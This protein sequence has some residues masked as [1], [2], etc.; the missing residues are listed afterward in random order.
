MAAGALAVVRDGQAEDQ[1]PAARLIAHVVADFNVGVPSG[2]FP[3]VLFP[4]GLLLESLPVIFRLEF[5]ISGRDEIGNGAFVRSRIGA[6]KDEPGVARRVQV[7]ANL[8]ASAPEFGRGGGRMVKGAACD[9][10]LRLQPHPRAHH[11][12]M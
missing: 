2:H 5:R 10:P 3:G 4:G 9:A 6:L 11:E 12:R 8:P 1:A 7:V